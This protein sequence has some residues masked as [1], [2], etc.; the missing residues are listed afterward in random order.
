MLAVAKG[1]GVSANYLARVCA[2]LDV[3][4][5]PRDA[6]ASRCVCIR[7]VVIARLTAGAPPRVGIAGLGTAPHLI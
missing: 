5:P 6:L 7:P 3:P 1:Y 2:S 4:W